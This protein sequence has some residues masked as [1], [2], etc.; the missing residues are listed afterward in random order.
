M[1]TP[2]T[3]Q[4][5]ESFTAP[6]CAHCTLTTTKHRC[7]ICNRRTTPLRLEKITPDLAESDTNTVYSIWPFER[8]NT[9]RSTG[10]RRPGH[11]SAR[12]GR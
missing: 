2:T 4:I 3:A 8:L 11:P 9:P 10:P 5:G 6:I 7:P 12:P 1:A